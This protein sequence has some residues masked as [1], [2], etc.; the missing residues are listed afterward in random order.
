LADEN[1]KLFW[2]KVTLEKIV[3]ESEIFLK[4]GGKSET[5]G[6]CIIASGDGR[7]WQ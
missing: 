1:R 5:G 2:G 3:K 7:P 6:K 4:I